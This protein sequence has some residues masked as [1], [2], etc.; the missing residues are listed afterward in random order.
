MIAA[1]HS[2]SPG[3]VPDTVA[4]WTENPGHPAPENAAL[5]PI[6]DIV[7]DRNPLDL[8]VG[9]YLDIGAGRT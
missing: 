9:F 6:G 7:R 1:R 8:A 3:D 4:K 5:W 2:G